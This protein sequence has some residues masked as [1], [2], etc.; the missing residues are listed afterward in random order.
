[1]R[2]LALA[3][4]LVLIASPVLAQG[5]AAPPA[6]PAPKAFTSAAEVQAIIERS[7]AAR[8][9]EP[10]ISTPLLVGSGQRANLEY[11]G[12]AGPAA[13]H[14]GESEAFYVIEGAGVMTTGGRIVGQAGVGA[15]L[16]I[17][18]GLAR[19]MTK[20]DWILVGPGEPHQVTAVDGAVVLM[21][22]HLK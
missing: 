22:V 2:A 13:V 21:S 20:G 11:R 4:S 17:E 9:N 19:R 8:K 18:G 1:M 16:S 5:P 3:L 10:N 7:R 15:G 14:P 6:P 12:S